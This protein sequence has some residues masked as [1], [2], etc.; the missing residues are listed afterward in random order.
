MLRAYR[1]DGGLSSAAD[2]VS[3][4]LSLLKTLNQT[5]PGTQSTQ[6]QLFRRVLKGKL[7]TESSKLAA[8]INLIVEQQLNSFFFL[9]TFL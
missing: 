6:V 3:A 1:Q 5:F 4:Q 7:N 9:F 8:I 2:I